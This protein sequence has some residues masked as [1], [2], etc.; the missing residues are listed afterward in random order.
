[1]LPDAEQ[2]LATLPQMTAPLALLIGP[3][4]GF[5]EREIEEARAHGFAAVRFGPRVLRTETAAL[6]ALAALN[7]LAGDY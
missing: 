7:A 1:L 2:S 4:G 5:A 3:E 6:A